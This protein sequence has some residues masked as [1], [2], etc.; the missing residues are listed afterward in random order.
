MPASIFC[1]SGSMTPK[2]SCSAGDVLTITLGGTPD[3][4]EIANGVFV[5]AL[6]TAALDDAAGNDADQTVSVPISIVTDSYV[7][8]ALAQTAQTIDAPNQIGYAVFGLNLRQPTAQTAHMLSAVSVSL[9]TPL[10]G[11]AIDDY[12]FALYRDVN[13]NG[14]YDYAVDT[15]VPAYVSAG[16]IALDAGELLPAD[17]TGA[18]AGYDWI[19]VARPLVTATLGHS[20][21]FEIAAGGV[22]VSNVT[23]IAGDVTETYTVRASTDYTDTA[24]AA[25]GVFSIAADA[26]LG[27]ELD[28]VAADDAET[29][30]F[31]A[32][33]G[34]VANFPN[35]LEPAGSAYRNAVEISFSGRLTD[36][37]SLTITGSGAVVVELVDGIAGAAQA[38]YTYTLNQTTDV[39]DIAAADLTLDLSQKL[40]FH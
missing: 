11:A 21:K 16:V 17:D 38:R 10:G 14:V 18:N 36:A 23:G 5:A 1:G 32:N 34:A 9:N 22:V 26:E 24:A 2:V 13:H 35:G 20:T 40:V 4:T 31:D 37:S 25:W 39:D 7:V 30:G 12:D 33:T 29:V 3:T 19:V 6:D 15:Y 28:T 8:Q 27:E